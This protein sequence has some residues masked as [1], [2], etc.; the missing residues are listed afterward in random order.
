MF[1]WLLSRAFSFGIIA[2][3]DLSRVSPAATA[4]GSYS[5]KIKVYLTGASRGSTTTF[6]IPFTLVVTAPSKFSTGASTAYIR[7]ASGNSAATSA[8]DIL[9]AS[10]SSTKETA[11]K[12][13]ITMTFNNASGGAMASG[14]TL[15]AQITN[16]PGYLVLLTADTPTATQCVVDPT[17]NATVGRAISAQTVDAVSNLIICADGTVGESTIKLSVTNQL[18]TTEWTT[19]TFT[20]YGPVRTLTTTVNASI[21]VAGGDTTGYGG[22][23]RTSTG[24]VTNPGVIATGNTTP[25]III[26]AKDA[27]GQLA[28]AA[29]APIVISSNLASVSGGTCT[30]DD[31]AT[32]YSSSIGV[33]VYNCNFTT[34]L[35]S[36]SGDKATLTFRIADP[37]GTDGV[38][39]LTTTVDVTVGG[40][41]FTETLS[42]DKASYNAGEAMVVTRTAKDSAGNPVADGSSAP[43]V[44]FNKAIG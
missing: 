10:G 31:G 4:A 8:T 25:A 43:A 36:K 22:A 29:A 30:L 41:R 6:D 1:W 26:S 38:D 40:A 19:K 14:N 12:G 34:T 27:A 33:G 16:G 9:S 11:N 23:S 20:F 24:E 18:A 5:A 39:Y 15:T 13:A 44:V 2:T 3:F 7:S 17:F 21:G 42:L 37:L 32:T 35:A 28:T